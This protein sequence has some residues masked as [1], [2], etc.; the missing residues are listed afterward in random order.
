[1]KPNL[2]A[3]ALRKIVVALVEVIAPSR[4]VPWGIPAR[5]ARALLSQGQWVRPAVEMAKA[6]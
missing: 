6:Q 4:N 1:M 2:E 5:D 3:A